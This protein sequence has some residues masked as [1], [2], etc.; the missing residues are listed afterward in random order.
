M[1]LRQAPSFTRIVR[2]HRGIPQYTAGHLARLE[3]IEAALAQHPG[4]FIAGNAYRG[5]S[6]NAC[7]ED[8]PR[9]AGRVAE[10]LRTVTRRELPLAR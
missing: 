8:A 10:H 1:G 3:R 4:L 7:I 9:L 5:V 2:H 6:V